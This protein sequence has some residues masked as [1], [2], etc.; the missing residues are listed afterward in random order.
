MVKQE[1]IAE[2]ARKQ[3]LDRIESLIEAKDFAELRKVLS[4]SRAADVA[5]VVEVLDEMARQVLFDV[6]DVKEVG[7]VL[8]KIDQATRSEVV[9]DLT[10]AEL[11]DMLATLPPDEAADVVADL[12]QEQ[13]EQVLGHIGKIESDE[14]EK[15][16]S[17][18]EDTAGGI[19]TSALVAVNLGA[20]IGQAIERFRQAD[21]DDDVFHVFVVDDGGVYK[22]VLDVRAL[23][24]H[25]PDTKVSGVLEDV[26]PAM[27]VNADQ[28]E[29]ANSFRK[30]DLI[31]MPVVDEKGVLLG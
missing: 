30:N 1:N 13:S 6:L 14:I 7:E 27:N 24:R 29:I 2:L 10:S 28:E 19:M 26:L 16:L 5:E 4:T 18:E 22:G 8:E 21:P 17:Y 9:E 31:V 11:T 3:L 12:S 15:L 20:T 23:L 25:P